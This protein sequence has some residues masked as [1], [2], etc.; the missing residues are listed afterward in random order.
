MD[1]YKQNGRWHAFSLLAVK[2]EEG[3]AGRAV[4]DSITLRQWLRSP[5]WS[6]L[7]LRQISSTLTIHPL[8]VIFIHVRIVEQV[9]VAGYLTFGF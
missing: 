3:H 1:N 8:L 4:E 6:P 7:L 2:A 5:I 9:I